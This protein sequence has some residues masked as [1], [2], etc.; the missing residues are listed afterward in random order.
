MQACMDSEGIVVALLIG[1]KKDLLEPREKL[2]VTFYIPGGC[3]AFANLSLKSIVHLMPLARSRQCLV[4]IPVHRLSDKAHFETM[5]DDVR[6]AYDTVTNYPQVDSERIAIWGHSS[7]GHL[8]SVLAGERPSRLL[9]LWAAAVNPKL[10]SFWKKRSLLSYPFA[11]RMLRQSPATA[12]ETCHVFGRLNASSCKSFPP[13]RI[14][15][16]TED[17]AVHPEQST[18]AEQRLWAL[19]VDVAVRSL[20]GCGHSIT[21]WR[22][23]ECIHQAYE[24]LSSALDIYVQ[25]TATKEE[26]PLLQRCKLM[27]ALSS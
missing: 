2:P 9:V 17:M 6:V 26:L 20:K 5:F 13:T 15:H 14:T 8:A 21:S 16:G 19:G 3:W 1:T 27:E 25:Y 23:G 12:P 7:G 24:D 10:I 18:Q 4:A 22:E 11:R